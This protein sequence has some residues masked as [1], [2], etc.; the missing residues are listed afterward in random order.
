MKTINIQ[1]I[2]LE[3]D[4]IKINTITI[5]PNYIFVVAGDGEVTITPKSP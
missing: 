5:Q 3:P 4:S 1:T 2:K